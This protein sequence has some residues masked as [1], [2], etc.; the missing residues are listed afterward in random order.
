MQ[1]DPNGIGNEQQRRLFNHIGTVR[2]RKGKL[3][4][5][6]SGDQTV[7]FVSHS[8]GQVE[9][10]CDR[11]IW[12]EGGNGAAEGATADVLAG[13]QQSVKRVRVATDR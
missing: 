11:A 9:K 2:P 4:E 6:I 13:Y 1:H 3:K 7:V 10:L 8:E 5:R 12:L